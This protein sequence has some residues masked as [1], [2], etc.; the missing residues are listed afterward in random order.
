MQKYIYKNTD[1]QFEK[2]HLEIYLK[3]VGLLWK[4]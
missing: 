4:N 2:Q 3:K 1:N